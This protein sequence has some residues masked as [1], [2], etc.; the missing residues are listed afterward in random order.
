M[1]AIKQGILHFREVYQYDK[2]DVEFEIVGINI[3]GK[4]LLMQVRAD[5]DSDVALEF[6]EKDNSLL[7]S[8]NST[9]STVVR[10]VKTADQMIIP[11]L[12][13]NVRPPVLYQFTIVMFTNDDSDNDYNDQIII[14]TQTIIIGTMEVL[15]NTTRVS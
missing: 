13:V 4:T 15:P 1:A 11:P 12:S 7:K 14:D 9:T 10:L 8:I 2:F 5:A 3:T 6:T